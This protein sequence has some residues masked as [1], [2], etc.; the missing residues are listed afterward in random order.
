MVWATAATRNA[1]TW[2]HIDDHGMA[3]IVKVMVG[4]KYWVT[5]RPKAEKSTVDMGSIRA[6]LDSFDPGHPSSNNYDHEGILLEAG[7]ILY[8]SI[9]LHFCVL[10]I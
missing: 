6:F 8:A 2:D 7:D 1:A 5:M 10:K 3:T 9:P 4:K